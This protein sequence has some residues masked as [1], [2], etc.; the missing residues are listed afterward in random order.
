MAA[1][2]C[3]RCGDD[4]PTPPPYGRRGRPP[5]WC[6]QQCRRAAY[7]ERR[8]AANGAIAVRIE[9]VEKPV[10]RVVERVRVKVIEQR[11]TPAKA[12]RI[13]LESPTACRTV[14][15]GLTNEVNSV[16]FDSKAHTAT[17]KAAEEL[18][19]ALRRRRHLYL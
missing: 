14:L 12:A 17:I 19:R 3:P 4:L 7:E 9:V 8:A 16:D 18:L 1:E 10:D 11:V 6:S 2:K 5:R 13:V 15:A